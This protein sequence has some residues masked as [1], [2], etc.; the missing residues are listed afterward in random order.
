MIEIYA[1]RQKSLNDNTTNISNVNN[2]Y[3][4]FVKLSAKKID[5]DENKCCRWN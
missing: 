3:A 1:N 4:N 5:H 2:T